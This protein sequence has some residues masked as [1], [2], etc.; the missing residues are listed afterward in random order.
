M[1][2]REGS[3]SI[4]EHGYGESYTGD[5]GHKQTGFRPLGWKVLLVQ[6]FLVEVGTEP[7]ERCHA[8]SKSK[9]YFCHR[10]D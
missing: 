1:D 10:P 9:L 2:A 4:N 8:T 3:P 5:H 6:M 7:K